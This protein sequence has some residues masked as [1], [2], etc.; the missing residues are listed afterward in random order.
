MCPD[1]ERKNTRIGSMGG[2]EAH[3]TSSGISVTRGS[4]KSKSID[5]EKNTRAADRH[6]RRDERTD[7]TIGGSIRW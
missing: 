2:Y 7:Y 5:F 6:S 3:R 1:Q 4:D